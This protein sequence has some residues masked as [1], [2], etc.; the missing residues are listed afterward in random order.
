MRQWKEAAGGW[1]RSGGTMVDVGDRG[2][3]MAPAQDASRELR[4]VAQLKMLHSLA[5]RLNQ[6]N[7]VKEIGDAITAELRTLLDYHNCRIY[8]LQDDGYTLVP[9]AF[10]GEL[11][12]YKGE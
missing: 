8:L 1:S 3:T 6:L 12:E 2:R 5:L 11:L 10:R 4:S 9:I 7:D